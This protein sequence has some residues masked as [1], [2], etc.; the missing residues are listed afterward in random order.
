M[1][2]TKA[3]KPNRRR[4]QENICWPIFAEKTKPFAGFAR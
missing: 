3:A 4:G 1:E 2:R